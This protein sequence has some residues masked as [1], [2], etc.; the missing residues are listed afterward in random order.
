MSRR[1]NLSLLCLALAA[2][3]A[4]ASPAGAAA[5]KPH[6]IVI[7][8]DD[9]GH[10]DVAFNGGPHSAAASVTGNITALANAGVIFDR[11][12]VHW[13]CSPTRRSFIS[14]R[15]PI[16]HGEQLSRVS[17]DDLDIRW[18]W[19]SEKLKSAG[20]VGHWVGE[21]APSAPHSRAAARCSPTHAVVNG[22]W[23]PP[24]LSHPSAHAAC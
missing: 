1:N 9:L 20:Y 14:G 15:L 17:T 18:T 13:H 3:L 22:L 24:P 2:W 10:N 11:H 7:L 5:P 16:H 23:L 8:Q 21:R 6:L 19:I 12:Y 4:Q